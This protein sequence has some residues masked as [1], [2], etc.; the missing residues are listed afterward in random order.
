MASAED[1]EQAKILGASSLKIKVDASAFC[2]Q[3]SS[4]ESGGSDEEKKNAVLTALNT[5]A[6][7][8]KMSSIDSLLIESLAAFVKAK[9]YTSKKKT[10][11]NALLFPGNLDL[12]S[13]TLGGPVVSL[14]CGF[15]RRDISTR[16]AS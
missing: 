1:P 10:Y 6:L 5:G 9:G 2:E 4:S 11:R 7:S 12:L 3:D 8:I 13:Q 15:I 16:G 14:V